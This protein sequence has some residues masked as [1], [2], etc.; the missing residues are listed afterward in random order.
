[1]V[2]E[3]NFSQGDDFAALNL[4]CVKERNDT[5]IEILYSLDKRSLGEKVRWKSNEESSLTMAF[6]SGCGP[7]KTFPSFWP[8][9]LTLRSGVSWSILSKPLTTL[10]AKATLESTSSKNTG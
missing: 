6:G 4:Y 3:T 2:L 5:F 10:E 8:A 7:C 1:M 9:F